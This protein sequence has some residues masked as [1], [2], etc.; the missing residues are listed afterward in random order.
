[1][2]TTINRMRSS[3]KNSFIAFPSKFSSPMQ[4][5]YTDY[6]NCWNLR[7]RT[8]NQVLWV[9]GS[10]VD[11]LLSFCQTCIEK[12]HNSSICLIDSS[13]FP[14]NTHLLGPFQPFLCTLSHVSS[15]FFV[16]DRRKI[17]TLSG[18]LMDHGLLALACRRPPLFSSPYKDPTEYKPVLRSSQTGTSF[19]PDTWCNLF[20]NFNIFFLSLLLAVPL[21]LIVPTLLLLPPT[22]PL[23]AKL[24]FAFDWLAWD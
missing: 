10:N 24:S 2:T 15:A 17:W 6:S 14:Y 11:V 4:R 23:S 13:S 12:S 3:S 9:W 20:S 22:I 18:H 1:M 7:R 8:Y 19:S 5:W 21:F 16:H